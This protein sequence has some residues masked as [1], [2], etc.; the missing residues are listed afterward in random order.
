MKFFR[1]CVGRE[2]LL[3]VDATPY[4]ASPDPLTDLGCGVATGDACN[5]AP[6]FG[7]ANG[8]PDTAGWIAQATYLP[9][10]N[11]QLGVQYTA[12]SKFNGG[13]DNYDG[14]GGNASDNNTL[15]VYRW[16]MR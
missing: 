3:S 4:P 16:F 14:L 10:Q 8:S 5:P 7:S 15:Y 11:V 13:S 9:W 12:Y 2:R 6:G 1:R